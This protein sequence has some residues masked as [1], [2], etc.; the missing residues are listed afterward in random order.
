MAESEPYLSPH[1]DCWDQTVRPRCLLAQLVTALPVQ[2]FIRPDFAHTW[3]RGLPDGYLSPPTT[4]IPLEELE[5][6]HNGSMRNTGVSGALAAGLYATAAVAQT[7]CSNIL[8]PTYSP[9]VVASGWQAQLVAGGLTKPRSI[10]FDST[11]A[12]LVVE[13]GQGIS[14]HRFTDNGGTCLASNHSHMLVDLATLNHGLALSNDG[15]TIYASSA[16]A[17]FAWAYDARG[18]RVTGQPQTIVA[19]MSNSDLVTRTLLMSKKQPGTLLVSRGSGD[20]DAIQTEDVTN[21]LSQIRA[22]NLT[23]LTSSSSPYNFNTDGAVLGWGL[24]NSVGVSEHPV[25]GGIYAVENSVDGVQR[26]GV[27]VHENNPGEELNF[28]GYL[29]GTQGGTGNFGYPHCFAVWQV[30]EIPENDGLAVGKQF[31]VQENS[32]LRDETCA[33]DYVPPRLTFPAHYAPLDI[34][35]SAGGEEAYITF[36]G[37]FDRSSPVGY[38]LSSIAFNA[39]TGEPVAAADSNDALTDVLTNPDNTACPDRC[40]RPVGLAFDSAGRLWMSS[41]STGE[42]Y[43]L[44]RT[45]ESGSGTF[46]QPSGGSGSGS[47]S[48]GNGG[49]SDNAAAG[50][51][52]SETA[53]TD[54]MIAAALGVWLAVV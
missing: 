36:R 35:F 15:N 50:L 54:W 17:V 11:G 29:N 39:A 40:F 28:L 10:A 20:N 42:I 51:R 12:L 4:G 7:Q 27:D 53:M 22:F 13:S 26:N 49:G 45:G 43:V 2:H 1:R 44:Q 23:N 21:G 41:D 6:L 9:P 37:S 5:S 14:R 24:R 18:G 38:R 34:K 19:N 46:V 25:T 8:V 47:N 31:A 16:E 33:E 30:D 48:G 32:T 3:T 52:A